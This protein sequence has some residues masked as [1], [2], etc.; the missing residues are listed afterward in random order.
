M[1]ITESA[2]VAE[3]L[4]DSIPNHE[5]STDILQAFGIFQIIKAVQELRI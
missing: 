1:E 3:V 5:S 4:S 2:A